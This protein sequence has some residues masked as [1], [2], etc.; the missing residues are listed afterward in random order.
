MEAAKELASE[1]HRSHMLESRVQQLEDMM[2]AGV[3]PAGG[4][5]S[6]ESTRLAELQQRLAEQGAVVSGLQGENASLRAELE[7][8]RAQAVELEG[9]LM[10]LTGLLGCG[11]V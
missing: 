4:A 8:Q 3:A 6:S 11:F 7:R 5:L 10:V 2:A 9:M 1:Q